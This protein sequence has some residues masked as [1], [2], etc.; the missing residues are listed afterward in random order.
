MELSMNMEIIDGRVAAGDLPWRADGLLG[1]QIMVMPGVPL[2]GAG[3]ADHWDIGRQLR[4]SI[5][6]ARTLVAEYARAGGL[7]DPEAIAEFSRSCVSRA[8]KKTF[9][10]SR[11]EDIAALCGEAL[12]IAAER[13]GL[14]LSPP[15]R[16]SGQAAASARKAAAGRAAGTQNIFVPR[17]IPQVMPPQPLGELP[18]LLRPKAWRRVAS[19]TVQWCTGVASRLRGGY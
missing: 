5:R 9:P 14:G 16:H 1:D 10:L 6:T 11:G 12:R 8:L 15:V 4:R 2:S 19:V 17:Q 18:A 13:F 7:R 3:L